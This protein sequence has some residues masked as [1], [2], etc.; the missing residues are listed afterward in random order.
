[1]T[2]AARSWIEGEANKGRKLM[3][4]KSNLKSDRLILLEQ[5]KRRLHEQILREKTDLRDRS[6]IRAAVR[7]RAL[8]EAIMR[9]AQAGHLEDSV[10]KMLADDLWADLDPSGAAFE[11]LN[12]TAFDL[13]GRLRDISIVQIKN[14]CPTE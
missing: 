7:A 6:R 1:L 9:L 4:R 3:R 14:L 11:S 12:G 5:R 2:Y 8:G 10:L 13:S